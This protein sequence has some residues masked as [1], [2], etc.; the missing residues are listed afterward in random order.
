MGKPNA[1]GW[2]D[3]YV[4]D[5]ERATSTSGRWQGIAPKVL[6]RSIRLGDVVHG[7]GGKPV[8]TKLHAVMPGYERS[9]TPGSSRPATAGLVSPG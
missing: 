6:H 8:R 2:F 9:L 4:D 5:I 7:H 1:I 3:L